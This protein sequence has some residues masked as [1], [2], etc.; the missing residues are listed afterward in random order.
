MRI[1]MLYFSRRPPAPGSAEGIVLPCEQMGV[2]RTPE[3][4]AEGHRDRCSRR[5][6]EGGEGGGVSHDARDRAAGGGR[7]TH[8]PRRRERG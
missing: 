6:E 2:G 5:M 8:T 4:R 3:A 7:H 1:Q